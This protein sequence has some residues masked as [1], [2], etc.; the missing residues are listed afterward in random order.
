MSAGPATQQPVNAG[1]PQHGVGNVPF[2]NPFDHPMFPPTPWADEASQRQTGV[3][4]YPQPQVGMAPPLVTSSEHPIPPEPSMAPEIPQPIQGLHCPGIAAPH[5]ASIPAFAKSVDYRTYRLPNMRAE[6]TAFEAANLHQF[7]VTLDGFTR[8][9]TFSGT[10]PITLLGFLQ[11]VTQAMANANI[12][13]GIASKIIPYSL[14]GEAS[15]TVTRQISRYDLHRNPYGATWPHIAHAL[16]GRFL[17]DGIL[18]DAH[19]KVMGCSQKPGE[20]EGAYFDRVMAAAQTCNTIFPDWEVT[21]AIVRGLNP[22][23]RDRVAEDLRRSPVAEQQDPTAARRL[24][25]N[26]GRTFRERLKVTQEK[27]K[28]AP[29]KAARGKALFIE[30][31]V[32]DSVMSVPPTPTTPGSRGVFDPRITMSPF[33]PAPENMSNL[34]VGPD[35]HGYTRDTFG[36]PYSLKDA[37]VAF[38]SLESILVTPDSGVPQPDVLSSLDAV[39]MTNRPVNANTIPT[40]TL[41]PEQLRLAMS[42][43]PEDYWSLSCWTCRDEGHSTYTCPYL[44]LAQRLWFAFKFYQYQ[45]ASN[46]QM[47][48]FLEQR[49]AARRER[50]TRS[51]D[52]QPRGILSSRQ[53]SNPSASQGQGSRQQ[54]PSRPWLRSNSPRQGRRLQFAPRAPVHILQPSTQPASQVPGH[55]VDSQDGAAEMRTDGREQPENYQG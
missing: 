19:D 26:E 16:L 27:L 18:R 51:A 6:L 54:G 9:A 1:V 49:A 29:S 24:A 45:I 50:L 47:K 35:G 17:N 46:P 32:P 8:S 7:R 48:G 40:P 34:H 52:G 25:V 53:P 33:G 41:T 11:T 30:D 39:D 20:E 21:Q 37:M 44:N 43:V 5:S 10:P 36:V 38:E 31:Q 14:T 3:P 15:T 55:P 22:T 13:E 2:T 4:S 42:V 23:I 12:S 28:P